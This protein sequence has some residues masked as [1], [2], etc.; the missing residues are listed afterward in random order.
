MLTRFFAIVF[1]MLGLL[2]AGLQAVGCAFGQSIPSKPLVILEH[3]DL[4]PRVAILIKD[5]DLDVRIRPANPMPYSAN[6][7]AAVWVGLRFPA[8]KA[9]AAIVA[10]RHYY[11]QLRYVALS[12]RQRGVPEAIHH[13]IFVGGSTESALRMG[14]LA[15]RDEDFAALEKV[16][17]AENL[18]AL[19]RS[20]YGKKPLLKPDTR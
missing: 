6:A 1:P 8:E 3:Q 10:A 16:K 17:T 13:Q 4:A 15:W 20:R 9:V 12:D 11:R 2:G 19:I 18:Q 7:S 5:M 14:L